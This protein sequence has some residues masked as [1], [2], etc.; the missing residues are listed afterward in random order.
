[1]DERLK[2]AM[3]AYLDN[4]KRVTSSASKDSYKFPWRAGRNRFVMLPFLHRVEEADLLRSGR[5][6]MG[7]EPGDVGKEL[8]FL[9]VPRVRYYIGPR[10]KPTHVI[11]GLGTPDCPLLQAWLA[12]T[13]VAKAERKNAEPQDEFVCNVVCMDQPERG[14]IQY[15]F[16]R[17][18]WLGALDNNQ[19]KIAYGVW[20]LIGG[21]A[22]ATREDTIREG[23]E[24]VGGSTPTLPAR[25]PWDDK[26]QGPLI[27]LKGREIILIK[28]SKKIGL[29]M[30]LVV[31]DT[32]QGGP[33]RLGPAAD[34]PAD[35]YGQGAPKGVK[36]LL[37]DPG[38]YPGWASNGEHLTEDAD[39]FAAKAVGIRRKTSVVVPGTVAVASTPATVQDFAEIPAGIPDE[40]GQPLPEAPPRLPLDPAPPPEPKPE[41]RKPGRPR[42]RPSADI[43]VGQTAHWTEDDV[44]YIGRVYK[45]YEEAGEEKA[46]M[47]VTVADQQNDRAR[48]DVQ[49]L[50]E[51]IGPDA[52]ARVSRSRLVPA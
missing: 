7:L 5:A 21:Y 3:K 27:G 22:P 44:T 25:A 52:V 2:Q 9:V 50:L 45:F 11:N 20:D 36:D 12:E 43:Q 14:V 18:E 30:A 32:V 29:N 6:A 51:R 23:E 26:T 40:S 17:S 1:M 33:L 31:D 41:G 8:P 39:V 15:G 49:T 35:F 4:R 37:L 10:G 28:K 19:A 42:K 46:E 48:A 13:G 34:L 47:E 24:A 16:R 38:S